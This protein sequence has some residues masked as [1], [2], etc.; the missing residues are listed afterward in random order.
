[1]HVTIKTILNEVMY[2]LYK[3][4]DM[5]GR[6]SDCLDIPVISTSKQDAGIY[7]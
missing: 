4:Q 7:F 2:K 6:N 5:H 3:L 1:M